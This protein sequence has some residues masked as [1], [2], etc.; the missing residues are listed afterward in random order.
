MKSIMAS[1]TADQVRR[2]AR[3]VRAEALRCDER[4]GEQCALFM[5]KARARPA[6]CLPQQHAEVYNITYVIM[7]H[8]HNTEL[9]T[10]VLLQRHAMTCT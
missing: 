1:P 3:I 9:Y 8:W 5:A 6:L 10:C 4:P 7:Q 2:H